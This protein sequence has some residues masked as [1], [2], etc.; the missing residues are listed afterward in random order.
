MT[1]VAHLLLGASMPRGVSDFR[2]HLLPHDMQYDAL[3]THA[4]FVAYTVKADPYVLDPLIANSDGT[5]TWDERRYAASRFVHNQW[6]PHAGYHLRDEL[7]VHPWF[8]L[9]LLELRIHVPDCH[10]RSACHMILPH[11]QSLRAAYALGGEIA[12]RE[13]LVSALSTDHGAP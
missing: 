5:Y 12:V 6:G 3:G 8:G 7:Q 4:D 1:P 9:S 11:T 13:L 2:L 10:L